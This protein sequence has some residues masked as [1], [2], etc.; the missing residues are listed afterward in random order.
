MRDGRYESAEQVVDL[1]ILSSARMIAT[2]P[3]FSAAHAGTTRA[4]LLKGQC[5]VRIV[6]GS[7]ENFANWLRD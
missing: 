4:E 1:L 2:T 3:E 5:A 6:R 7:R